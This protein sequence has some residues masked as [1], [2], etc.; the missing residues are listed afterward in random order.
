MFL[1][2]VFIIDIW[3]HICYCKHRFSDYP[4]PKSK[5]MTNTGTP[6][7]MWAVLRML[8]SKTT[9]Q[10]YGIHFCLLHDYFWGVGCPHVNLHCSS[11]FCSE[12]I[13]VLI[14]SF[15][16]L[17]YSKIHLNKETSKTTLKSKLHFFKK[18]LPQLFQ[19]LL[20]YSSEIWWVWWFRHKCL[21]V[22]ERVCMYMC[23]MYVCVCENIL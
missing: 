13:L 23:V 5:Y 4:D 3:D 22:Y 15:F 1:G 17:F 19:T 6:S 11:Y 7:S 9:N 10:V 8:T 21:C 16:R 12:D 20:I 2:T 18:R 14:L